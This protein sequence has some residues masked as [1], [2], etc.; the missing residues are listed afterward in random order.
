MPLRW[1][2]AVSTLQ[3][4]SAAAD[5]GPPVAATWCR[6]LVE[7]VLLTPRDLPRQREEA[8]AG[9]VTAARQR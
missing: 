5:D 2:R 6:P 4:W 7:P 1:H 8:D 3:G 9:E